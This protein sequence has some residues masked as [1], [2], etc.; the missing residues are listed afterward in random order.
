MTQTEMRG[1]PWQRQHRRATLAE[2][3][4]L[5]AVVERREL[6]K[7]V[8]ARWPRAQ[9]VLRHARLHALE[10]V[11]DGEHLTAALAHAQHALGVVP[12]AADRALDVTDEAHDVVECIAS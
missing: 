9:R 4:R 7:A 8:H 10:L 1:E 5:L 12:M 2:R 11:A 6:A 3:H